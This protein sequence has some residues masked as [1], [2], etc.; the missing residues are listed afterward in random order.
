MEELILKM[1]EESMEL[2]KAVTEMRYIL[3]DL[4]DEIEEREIESASC[5]WNDRKDVE[6]VSISVSKIKRIMGMS[7]DICK[8]AN[9]ILKKKESG[10]GKDE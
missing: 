4:Q 8:R 3:Y 5:D 7:P 10:D 2:Q 6:K 9:E 1:H